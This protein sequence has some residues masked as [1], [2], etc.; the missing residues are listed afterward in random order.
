MQEQGTHEPGD[1]RRMAGR[2]I[3]PGPQGRQDRLH[4]LLDMRRAK[5]AVR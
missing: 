1:R 5:H 4:G 2:V 3:A